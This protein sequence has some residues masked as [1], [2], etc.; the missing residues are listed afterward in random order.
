ML[1]FSLQSESASSFHGLEGAMGCEGQRKNGELAIRLHEESA[2]ALGAETDSESEGKV[3]YHH[4]R[5]KYGQF[6]IS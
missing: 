1:K 5:G 4:V 6:I 2:V 3:R